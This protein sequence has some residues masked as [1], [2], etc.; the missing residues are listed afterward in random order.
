MKDSLLLGGGEYRWYDLCVI[1]ISHMGSR[2]P[3]KTCT[4]PLIFSGV[5][6]IAVFNV[7]AMTQFARVRF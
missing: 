1:P 3:R 6:E 7:G 5:L 4:V 2:R